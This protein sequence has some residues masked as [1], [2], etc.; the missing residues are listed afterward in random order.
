LGSTQKKVL[1]ALGWEPGSHP[2]SGAQQFPATAKKSAI[3]GFV[4]EDPADKIGLAE[5][6]LP[7]QRW[8]R[9]REPLGPMKAHDEATGKGESFSAAD[10]FAPA[11]GFPCDWSRKEMVAPPTESLRCPAG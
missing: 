4:N 11:G 6:V 8:W 10:R 1:G 3:L 5:F 7:G 2:Q 9:I